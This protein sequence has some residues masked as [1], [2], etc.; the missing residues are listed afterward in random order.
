M[1]FRSGWVRSAAITVGG[2]SLVGLAVGVLGLAEH[3]PA[4]VLELLSRWG[5]VWLLVLA[6]MFLLWDLA[7]LALG[8]LG[9]LAESVQQTAV[10][11]NRIAD[12][13]DRERDRM[14]TEIAFVGQRMERVSREL[15]ESRREQRDHNRKVSDMLEKLT[16]RAEGK[17]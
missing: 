16:S 9:N 3:Q 4:Q 12:R 2:V 8:Y 11:M 15:Q 7:K 10:A 5:F 17:G 13:D 1:G 14:G 6:A